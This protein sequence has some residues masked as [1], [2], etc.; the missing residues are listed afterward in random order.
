MFFFYISSDVSSPEK[1]VIVVFKE[2]WRVQDIL[3]LPVENL[4]Q[5]HKKEWRD[6]VQIF[7]K[8]LLKKFDDLVSEVRGIKDALGQIVGGRKKGKEKNTF[9]RSKLMSVVGKRFLKFYSMLGQDIHIRSSSREFME[10]FFLSHYTY[11]VSGT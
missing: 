1:F 3:D 10:L 8:T 4:D 11:G 7:L 9:L 5:L 2:V 6:E